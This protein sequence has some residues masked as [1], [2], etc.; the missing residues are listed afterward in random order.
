MAAVIERE[1]G[2]SRSTFAK[3][4]N[5][6]RNRSIF[7]QVLVFGLIGA[8][9]LWTTQLAFEIERWRAA[10]GPALARWIEMLGEIEALPLPDAEVDVA[11]SNCVLNLVP[12]KAAAFAEIH[13]VL[14]PGG[15][16]QIADI[17]VQR[18]VSEA[19]KTRIDLWTG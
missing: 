10:C 12:D 7:W 6:E 17:M 19:A 16:L 5:D 2:D 13:R 3:I 9:L 15:R 14:K 4:V 8:L 1:G 18:P 11:V